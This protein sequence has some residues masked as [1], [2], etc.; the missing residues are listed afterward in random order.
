M[1]ATVPAGKVIGTNPAAG[2]M[3]DKGS[4]VQLLVST[5]PQTIAVPNVVGQARDPA[6]QALTGAGLSVQASCASG[7]SLVVTES[8]PAGSQVNPGSTVA[9]TCVG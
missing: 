4:P 8:P 2:T 3:L 7:T 5:G 1:S 6:I 9:I